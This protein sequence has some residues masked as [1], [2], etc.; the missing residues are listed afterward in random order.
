MP[1]A[2]NM[3]FC[4]VDESIPFGL[5][6]QKHTFASSIRDKDSYFS[7]PVDCAPNIIYLSI[8][9]KRKFSV[10]IHKINLFLLVHVKSVLSAK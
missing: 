2:I 7:A 1:N 4:F 9:N 8:R 10:K 5:R 6:A 3:V